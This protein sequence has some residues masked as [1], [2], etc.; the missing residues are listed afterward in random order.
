MR[1]TEKTIEINLDEA[2]ASGPAF[3]ELIGEVQRFVDEVGLPQL[4]VFAAGRAH[5]LQREAPINLD[6]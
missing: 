3:E 6:G 4:T 1:H 2:A 5:T